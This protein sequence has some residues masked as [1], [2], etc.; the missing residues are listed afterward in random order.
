MRFLFPNSFFRKNESQSLPK[1]V[2]I[3]VYNRI[4]VRADKKKL[5]LQESQSQYGVKT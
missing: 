4:R 3:R 1:K 5:L 2:R